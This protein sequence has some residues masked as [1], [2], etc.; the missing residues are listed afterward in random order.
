MHG[1]TKLFGSIVASTVWRESKETKIVWITML[2]MSGRN[3]VVE[4]SI[5]GLADLARVS[6]VECEG[7]LAALSAPDPYSRSKEASGRRIEA[8]DGGWRLINHA[9]YRAKMSADDRREYLRQKQAEHRA[10]QHGVNKRN[11]SSTESTHT[12]PDPDPD[13][14]A[15]SA[16]ERAREDR[17]KEPDPEPVP[18]AA[19]ARSDREDDDPAGRGLTGPAWAQRWLQAFGR[20]WCVHSGRIAYGNGES[21]ARA[22][23]RMGDKLGTLAPTEQDRAWLARARILAG[24]F[25]G[26]DAAAKASGFAF[27]FF[28]PRFDALMAEAGRTERIERAR[29]PVCQFHRTQPAAPIRDLDKSPTCPLCDRNG[30]VATAPGWPGRG[31]GEP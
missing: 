1:Y 15:P 21:D 8:I 14:T 18:A 30:V 31:S 28:V 23:A 25:G 10:R 3:G 13:Q 26:T 6:I 4:G 7:A 27:A 11:G 2:A 12:D 9:K 16:L 5:P 17:V 29:N 22:L 24:Y 20:A 19:S